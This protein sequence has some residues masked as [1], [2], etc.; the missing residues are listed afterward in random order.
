M[1]WSDQLIKALDH[2]LRRELLRRLE[3]GEELSPTQL[4]EVVATRSLPNVSYHV[5]VL[6]EYGA[7]TLSRCES[8]QGSTEH[9]YVSRVSGNRKVTAIL[10]ET[11]DKDR[12]SLGQP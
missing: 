6:A 12:A 10:K 7:L 8:V 11:K 2:P 9:F 3:N 5:R 4:T 1:N